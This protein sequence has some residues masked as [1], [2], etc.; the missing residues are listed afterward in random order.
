MIRVGVWISWDHLEAFSDF[1]GFLL[2]IIFREITI[3]PRFR[4]GLFSVPAPLFDL[5]L[6]ELSGVLLLGEGSR[7]R[8]LPLF[9]V[10]PTGPGCNMGGA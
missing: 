4:N 5:I 8:S 2:D 3:P 9:G 6:R 10:T 1:F 7:P